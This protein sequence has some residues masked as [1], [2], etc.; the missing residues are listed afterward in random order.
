MFR[1]TCLVYFS[2][3]RSISQVAVISCDMEISGL[4]LRLWVIFGVSTFIVWLPRSLMAWKSF[5]VQMLKNMNAL[6]NW[7]LKMF[8][9]NISLVSKNQTMH[10]N[11]NRNIR[12]QYMFSAY[13]H[14]IICYAV[15][16]NR[17]NPSYPTFPF[18][19]CLCLGHKRVCLGREDNHRNLDR[20]ISFHASQ[21]PLW[22]CE[23]R[24]STYSAWPV[25]L[26]HHSLRHMWSF[27]EVA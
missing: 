14:F 7:V 6:F 20:E 19:R 4:Y 10:V 15:R 3:C 23:W 2:V 21:V 22:H 24:Q 8:F 17:F 12:L 16:L 27:E 25:F 18:S 5:A 11:C 26:L 1:I 9:W 13:V